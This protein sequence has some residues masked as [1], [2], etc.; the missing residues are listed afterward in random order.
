[1]SMKRSNALMLSLAVFLAFTTCEVFAQL[2]PAETETQVPVK[3]R[4]KFSG[5]ENGPRKKL[6]VPKGKC[7]DSTECGPAVTNQ[8]R[9]KPQDTD[10]TKTSSSQTQQSSPITAPER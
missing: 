1:M 7:V 2:K 8:E 6:F 9:P 5:K 3:K 10:S 4:A